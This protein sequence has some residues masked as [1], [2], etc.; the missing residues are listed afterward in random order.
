MAARGRS[1]RPRGGGVGGD[2][3]G[4]GARRGVGVRGRRVPSRCRSFSWARPSPTSPAHCCTQRLAPWRS[5][6]RRSSSPS[7]RDD[8]ACNRI[9]VSGQEGPRS[10]IAAR[11]N[12]GHNKQPRW[13]DSWVALQGHRCV[14][15]ACRMPNSREP[16]VRRGAPTPGTTTRLFDSQRHHWFHPRR[17]PR[18]VE[19]RDQTRRDH[20][21]DPGR[22]RGHIER[23][24]HDEGGRQRRR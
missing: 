1:R 17:P 3:R 5:A 14:S 7:R 6:G 15:P 2:A 22:K 24:H 8:S 11:S 9:V 21:D 16:S 20:D 10:A 23:I 19:R 13:L 12:F 18:R 4:A